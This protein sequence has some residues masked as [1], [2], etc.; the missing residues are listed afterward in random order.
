[1]STSIT[2]WEMKLIQEHLISKYNKLQSEREKICPI[3]HSQTN[4]LLFCS[5]D[6]QGRAADFLNLRFPNSEKKK[7]IK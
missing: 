4:D 1:M 3:L 5:T 2:K 6:E 7:K